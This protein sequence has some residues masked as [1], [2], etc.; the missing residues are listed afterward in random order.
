MTGATARLTGAEA[1]RPPSRLVGE[2][3]EGRKN[4]GGGSVPRR[5]RSHITPG[6]FSSL[7]EG[8]AASSEHLVVVE[9]CESR[10]IVSQFK[11]SKYLL[12]IA[13]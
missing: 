10:R 12:G 2:G 7:G 13:G 4:G 6:I 1:L 11:P 5:E 3:K 8:A 9:S